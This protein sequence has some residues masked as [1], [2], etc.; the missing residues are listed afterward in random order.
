[1]KLAKVVLDDRQQANE[2]CECHPK[3]LLL[4]ESVSRTG[5]R[6]RLAYERGRGQWSSAWRGWRS[7]SSRLRVIPPSRP[8]PILPPRLDQLIAPRGGRLVGSPA[9]PGTDAS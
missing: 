6:R 1:M 5:Q 4:P 2:L 7:G 3:R 9:T 8:R